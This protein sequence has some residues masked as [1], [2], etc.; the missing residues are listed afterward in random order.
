MRRRSAGLLAGYDE[1][2]RGM[3]NYNGCRP[4]RTAKPCHSPVSYTHLDVY[5]R[6]DTP[7][8][9]REEAF[10]IL[11]EPPAVPQKLRPDM[12]GKFRE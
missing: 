5:K 2:Q 10:K 7:M 11:D 4:Q 9:V 6:Q 1:L 3:T 12:F 8:S